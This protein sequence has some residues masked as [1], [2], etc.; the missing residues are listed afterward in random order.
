MLVYLVIYLIFYCRTYTYCY[1]INKAQDGQKYKKLRAL[2]SVHSR[3]D[4]QSWCNLLLCKKYLLNV[5][6]DGFNLFRAQSKC[7]GL[8]TNQTSDKHQLNVKIFPWH[9][10]LYF[11]QLF[12]GWIMIIIFVNILK[13]GSVDEAVWLKRYRSI[14]EKRCLINGFA[15]RHISVFHFLF[16][17]VEDLMI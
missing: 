2:A 14:F 9:Y 7:I 3:G 11:I 12:F 5:K 16:W 1:L 10:V 8:F 13:V 4:S 15:L 6:C 17:K